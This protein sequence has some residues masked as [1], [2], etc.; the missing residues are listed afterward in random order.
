[1][2]K[3]RF[4]SNEESHESPL[5]D[6]PCQNHQASLLNFYRTFHT[7][8]PRTATAVFFTR[9]PS[10]QHNKTTPPPEA[11][12]L[13]PAAVLPA[14]LFEHFF[15]GEARDFQQPAPPITISG[16]VT[17]ADG[18]ELADVTIVEVGTTNGAITT[19]LRMTNPA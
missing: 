13:A 5:A 16:K 14:L 17:A 18:E 6:Y 15:R 7:L 11:Q 2:N 1:M 19:A 10:S 3:G 4:T 9:Y 8:A 12:R